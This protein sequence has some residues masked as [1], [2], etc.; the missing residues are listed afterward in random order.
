MAESTIR[1][2]ILNLAIKDKN[3]LYMAYMPFINNGGLF[4]P[5]N[6]Q[7]EIGQEIFVLLKLA[8]EPQ[9]LPI[10]GKVVWKT[11]AGSQNNQVQGIGIQFLDQDGLVARDKIETH[12]AG[13]LGS[14]RPTYTM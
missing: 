6:R 1:S 14:D 7:Y 10:S 13:A 2:S 8:D 4:I 11:P 3:A 9:P 12:L 5:T